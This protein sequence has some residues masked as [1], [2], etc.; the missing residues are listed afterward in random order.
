M[1]E[2]R[3]ELET[4]LQTIPTGVIILNEE[5][6]MQQTNWAATNL[7]G[8]QS[9][10]EGKLQPPLELLFPSD[11]RDDLWRMVRRCQRTGIGAGDFE[12]S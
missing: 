6:L 10:V 4:I 3:R 9:L 11:Q 5:L 7:L 8:L 1:Q 2:R 12:F